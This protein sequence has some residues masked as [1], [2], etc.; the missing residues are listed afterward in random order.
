[1]DSADEYS[2]DITFA[3]KDVCPVSFEP[4]NNYHGIGYRGLDPHAALGHTG[5]AQSTGVTGSGRRGIHGQ[6]C[7]N[8]GVLS[9]FVAV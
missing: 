4:K 9:A 2:D 3:P 6:V 1:M 8:Y 5:L 7:C